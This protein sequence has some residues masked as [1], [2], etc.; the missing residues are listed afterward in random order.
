MT[1]CN[2]NILFFFN[3]GRKI[4]CFSGYWLNSSHL[5]NDF[6]EIS[7]SVLF[8]AGPGR[9]W[10]RVQTSSWKK[11][12]QEKKRDGR[13]T[14]HPTWILTIWGGLSMSSL[15]R[16][17][18]IFHWLSHFPSFTWVGKKEGY[19]RSIRVL[20]D[21]FQVW[22]P[23]HSLLAIFLGTTC[24]LCASV[25]MTKTF[26]GNLQQPLLGFV[27]STCIVRSVVQE[28]E[29]EKNNAR[30]YIGSIK[31]MEKANQWEIPNDLVLKNL[32]EEPCLIF[33]YIITND[34]YYK[35]MC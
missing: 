32:Q 19:L 16:L 26:C 34:N 14:L 5:P 27:G 13:L 12:C 30:Q 11:M 8:T 9:S 10:E 4:W 15:P 21:S 22:G 31:T 20:S 6:W 23:T 3:K 29:C 2:L 28:Q 25:I 24:L 7:P 35:K 33:M 18:L 1:F 17:F